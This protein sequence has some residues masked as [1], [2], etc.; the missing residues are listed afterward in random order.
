M[1]GLQHQLGQEEG[2]AQMGLDGGKAGCGFLHR[3]ENPRYSHPLG[4]KIKIED[5]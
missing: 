3:N 5:A 4:L 2:V 1:A